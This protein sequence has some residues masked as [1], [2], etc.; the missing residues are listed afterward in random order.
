[1]PIDGVKTGVKSQKA[2][3]PS[4]QNLWCNLGRGARPLKIH[5]LNPVDQVHPI[6]AYHILTLM[7]D[8][9]TLKILNHGSVYLH[10]FTSRAQKQC[11]S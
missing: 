10:D 1:M 8:S 3:S 2:N 6:D 9:Y 11:R 5:R 4:A 7:I